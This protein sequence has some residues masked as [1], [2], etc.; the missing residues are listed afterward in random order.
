MLPKLY[1]EFELQIRNID[2][3]NVR[4]SCIKPNYVP[5]V[6]IPNEVFDYYSKCANILF[7]KILD[8]LSQDIGFHYF[9]NFKISNMD[10]FNLGEY[11]IYSNCVHI[12]LCNLI[13]RSI[14]VTKK[15]NYKNKNIDIYYIID[16]STLLSGL[17]YIITHEI[18]HSLLYLNKYS[19]DQIET[20]IDLNTISFITKHED[21]F[22]LIIINSCKFKEFRNQ[23]LDYYAFNIKREFDFNALVNSSLDLKNETKYENIS[24]ETFIIK[25]IERLGVYNIYDLYDNLLKNN[26]LLD[27]NVFKEN[28]NKYYN[29]NK[30]FKFI[31]KNNGEYNLDFLPILNT[32]LYENIYSNT[33]VLCE[34]DYIDANTSRILLNITAKNE[35]PL[36]FDL[37]EK[38]KYDE[39]EDY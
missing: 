28:N 22:N 16:H 11:E 14:I 38:Y 29:H 20:I 34:F 17:I 3:T 19:D 10:T 6:I 37:E 4:F 8:I 30:N 15:F 25:L 7:I 5:D 36:E 39:E 35:C 9:V 1:K 32:I 12:Y 31:I 2:P 13:N 21:I 24:K 23:K 33:I 26:I 27:I 18:M